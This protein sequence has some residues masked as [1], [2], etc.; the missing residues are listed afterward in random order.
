MRKFFEHIWIAVRQVSCELSYIRILYFTYVLT[1][2]IGL[3]IYMY[4]NIYRKIC[5]TIED[6][7]RYQV[8]IIHIQVTTYDYIT[9]SHSS[10]RVLKGRPAVNGKC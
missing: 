10:V 2:N 9:R 5:D 1:V 7:W 8:Y 4:V 6:M 3:C